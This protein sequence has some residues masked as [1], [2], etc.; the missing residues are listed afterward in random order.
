MILTLIILPKKCI[1]LYKKKLVIQTPK[2][3]QFI[4]SKKHSHYSVQNPKSQNPYK[5]NI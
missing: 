3:H 5:S 1:K 4:T 2:T